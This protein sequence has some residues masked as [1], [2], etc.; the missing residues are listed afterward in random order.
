MRRL[1][2][3]ASIALILSGCVWSRLLD[4]KGQLKEFDHYVIAV[5]EGQALVLQ[6]KEPCIR[7]ADIGYL[8]GGDQPSSTS[9]RKTG[10]N[11]VTWR[12]RR[13]RADSFGLDISLGAKDLDEETLADSL[14]VPPQVLAFIPKEQLLAAARALGSAEIDQSKREASAGFTDQQVKP[15]TP[16]REAIVAALGEPDKSEVVDGVDRMTFSFKI[17]KPDGTL[18]KATHLI[19]DLR[20]D[21]LVASRLKAPNFNAWMQ[22]DKTK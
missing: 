21:L 10:G 5:D 9:E 8:F 3:L 11:L 7:P 19:L 13:D 17:V 2:I 15:I 22:F 4:W 14:V 18:G 20:G 12:L 1:L 6:F 16:G